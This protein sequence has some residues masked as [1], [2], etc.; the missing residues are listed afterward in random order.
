MDKETKL[1]KLDALTR[2]VEEVIKN[3]RLLG[4]KLIDAGEFDL[5]K[6]VIANGF[7]HD[8]SKF[9]ALEWETLTKAED[10]GF[11]DTVIKHHNETNMHHPE[12]WGGIKNMPQVY[13]AEMICDWKARSSVMGTDLKKWIEESA[14]KR[15]DFTKN[16]QVHR[17]IMKYV[18]MVLEQRL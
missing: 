15:W 6:R 11:L 14:M 5:G 16:M 12:F 8:Q 7:L 9:H 18:N 2:H 1:D 3:C 13:L 17:D 4:H 10:N